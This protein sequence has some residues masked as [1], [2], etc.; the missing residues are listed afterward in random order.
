M[1]TF[2][3]FF[4]LAFLSESLTEYFFAQ[5]A[6]KYLKYV[7]AGVGV[8]LSVAYRADILSTCLGLDCWFPVVGPFVGMFLTGLLLGRGSNW[9]HDLASKYFGLDA[10]DGPAPERIAGYS[11][12]PPCCEGRG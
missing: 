9:L 8:F 12:A 5:W 4:V 10:E 3:V 11:T 6:G 7:S 2:T 1:E